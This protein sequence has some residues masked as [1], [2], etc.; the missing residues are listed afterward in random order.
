MIKSDYGIL[1]YPTFY[2]IAASPNLVGK[3]GSSIIGFH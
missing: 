3:K 1:F 2:E